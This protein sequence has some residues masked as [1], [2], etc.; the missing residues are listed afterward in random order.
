MN[1]VVGLQWETGLPPGLARRLHWRRYGGLRLGVADRYDLIFLKLYAAADSVGPESVH[2]QDLVALRPTAQ[3][4]QE[5]V[6]WVREQ[7]PTPAFAAALD[8][9]VSH[10]PKISR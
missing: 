3:E 6:A 5:A 2:F 7:D 4:L 10:V 9:V 8:L 1:S